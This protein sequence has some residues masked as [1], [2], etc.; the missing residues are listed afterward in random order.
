LRDG[1]K[2][3]YIEIFGSFTEPFNCVLQ[4]ASPNNETDVGDWP[5]C[6]SDCLSAKDH[7]SM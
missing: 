6:D 7:Q 2:K 5:S 4:V 3:E 1:Q